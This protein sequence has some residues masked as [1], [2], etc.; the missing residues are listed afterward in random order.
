MFAGHS[1]KNIGA[2][3]DPA[4]FSGVIEVPPGILGPRDGFVAVD[5]VEPG[6]DPL[7][8]FNPVIQT[9]VFKDSVPWIVIRVGTQARHAG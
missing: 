3:C 5:L 2:I 1:P 7:E 4:M 8:L 6:C 9:Q